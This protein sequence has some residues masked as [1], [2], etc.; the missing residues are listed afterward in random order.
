MLK[1]GPF[2][3]ARTCLYARWLR[4]LNRVFRQERFNRFLY[5]LAP[6]TRNSATLGK[7]YL[8]SCRFKKR[9]RNRHMFKTTF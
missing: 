1:Q 5:F 2:K 9:L 4:F 3:V 6:L 7:C 8:F